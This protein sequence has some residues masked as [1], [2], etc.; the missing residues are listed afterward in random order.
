AACQETRDD[1][2]T[3][4]SEESLYQHVGEEI[5]LET[6][7]EWVNYHREQVLTAARDYRPAYNV[8]ANGLE[9]MLNSVP[10]FVGVA[11]HYA[12]DDSDVL[13]ILAIPIGDDMLLWSPTPDRIIIDTNTGEPLDDQLAR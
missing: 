1:I 10:S 11:F 13:H 2:K 3:P 5:P 9:A 4:V 6:A 12:I 7:L 8:T